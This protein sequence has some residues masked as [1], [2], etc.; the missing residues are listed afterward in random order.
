MVFA[1]SNMP[2]RMR[3]ILS[4]TTAGGRNGKT[5]EP[6]NTHTPR[7]ESFCVLR[8]KF[9]HTLMVSHARA[10]QKQ[11]DLGLPMEKTCAQ[12]WQLLSHGQAL[13]FSGIP[14]TGSEPCH[15]DGRRSCPEHLHVDGDACAPA[16][17]LND[18]VSPS[19]LTSP[20]RRGYQMHNTS[21]AKGKMD[22]FF[23]PGFEE[24]FLSAWADSAW[25]PGY[26]L[27]FTLTLIK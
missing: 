27:S 8:S 2:A 19:L 12:L 21:I 24:A 7:G 22:C 1:S 16:S 23:S 25:L 9:L 26:S 3:K 18:H 13:A 20:Q 14:Q 11:S 17:L 10:H 15:I 5:T 4:R 6:A